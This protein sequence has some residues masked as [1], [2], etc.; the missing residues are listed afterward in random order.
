MNDRAD[1]ASARKVVNGRLGFNIHL[2]VYL[3]VNALLIIINLATSSGYLWFLWP[4]FGWG[5]GLLAHA[6]ATFWLPGVRNRM[7]E[8]EVARRNAKE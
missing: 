7:I 4:L 5:L 8:K 2:A 1:S 6:A 3:A